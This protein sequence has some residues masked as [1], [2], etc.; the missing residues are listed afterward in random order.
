MR[1]QQGLARVDVI[2]GYENGWPK[3]ENRQLQCDG[4][5]LHVY[6]RN[7]F[8]KVCLCDA[9]YIAERLLSTS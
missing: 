4:R 6:Y 7:K 1:K 9:G 3:R 5:G 8:D 2:I